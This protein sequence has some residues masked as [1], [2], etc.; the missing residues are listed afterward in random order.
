VRVILGE[1]VNFSLMFGC[2][3]IMVTLL[4]IQGG[5]NMTGTNCDLFTHKSVPVI[6]EPPCILAVWKLMARKINNK[7]GPSTRFG[8]VQI[9][10]LTNLITTLQGHTL[11]GTVNIQAHVTPIPN[12]ISKWVPAEFY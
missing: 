12:S 1:H 2:C 5:S 9:W 6:F 4:I 7:T 11:S 8:P 3:I 10:L